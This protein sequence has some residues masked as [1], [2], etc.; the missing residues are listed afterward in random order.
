MT[1]IIND[2]PDT[3]S[4]IE[5]IKCFTDSTGGANILSTE[6]S[7]TGVPII[8]KSDV[9]PMCATTQPTK[10]L[11]EKTVNSKYQS[12]TVV[13]NDLLLCMRDLS[14]R[15]Q[16][17]GLISTC[18]E[19]QIGH[20]VAQ[21]VTLLR[22]CL[23]DR[24][25]VSYFSNTKNY[26][27]YI[28]R[29]KRGSTQVHL[30]NDDIF[31]LKLPLPP[32]LEQKRIVAK[33]ESTQERIKAIEQSVTKAEE[34]IGKYREAL[35]Q[36]A[37]RGELV[38]QDPKDEPASKLL[39]RIR[40]DR[41]KQTDGKKRKKDDLPPIKPEEI[42]FEIPKS[43]E[44][45]QL[46]DVCVQ[47]T[48]G[49]HS[50]PKRASSGHLLLSARNV[51]NEGIR[52]HKVDF[53]STDVFRKIRERCAPQKGDVFLS[54]S[55]SVGWS[56]LVDKDDTY[57]LVRSAALIKPNIVCLCADYLVHALRSDIL[58]RQILEK[59]KSTAQANI[60]LGSISSLLL[61]LPPPAEQLSIVAKLE[62]SFSKF[63]TLRGDIVNTKAAITK[64]SQAILSHAFSGKLVQQ[65]PIEG[66]GH[67]LIEKIKL[68]SAHDNARPSNESKPKPKKR[69]KK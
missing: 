15:A 50:T 45:V 25:Y 48:D 33:I 26:R 17:L 30:G 21:G 36:K 54:C 2:A 42:P 31:L 51:T 11:P 46:G 18:T 60:F 32:T 7:D 41:S 9:Q 4:E 40:A 29:V 69:A 10:F 3:W 38:P 22:G 28:L 49:D 62:Q 24:K 59:S 23:I 13:R 47:I 6:Y 57:A 65:N 12:R 55:G 8:L 5:I 44:W 19:N 43:W 68:Q 64:M 66:T 52:L 61:P 56:C 63:Q 16:I 39:E 34:L 1:R 37:F 67:E 14:Q 53:V 20:L 27:D 58:Q 35:L